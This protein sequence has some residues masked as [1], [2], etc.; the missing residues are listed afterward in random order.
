MIEILLKRGK[1]VCVYID[2]NLTTDELQGVALNAGLNPLDGATALLPDG[3][4]VASQEVVAI[5]FN[6]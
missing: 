2:E 3:T 5:R 6:K 1:W 4:L